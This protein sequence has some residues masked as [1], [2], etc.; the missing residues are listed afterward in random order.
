MF[1]E[2]KKIHRLHVQQRAFVLNANEGS[3]VK[4]R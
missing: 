4:V 1:F 2:G 3:V